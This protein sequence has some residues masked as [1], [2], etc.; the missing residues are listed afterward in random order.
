MKH[1]GIHALA[2]GGCLCLLYS[3]YELARAS[4]LAL[5]N[6]SGAAGVGGAVSATLS[7]VLSIA[8][9]QLYGVGAEAVGAKWTL[10]LS[11]GGCCG[12]FLAFAVACFEMDTIS[13]SV[14]A[15]LFAFRETYVAL[16]GTQVWGL[17]SSTLKRRGPQESRRWFCIIQ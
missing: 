9:L 6:R 12:I 14:V 11:A 8:T 3:G 7:F 2:L 15:G 10:L 5:F 13:P 1:P 4:S 16:I 17:L